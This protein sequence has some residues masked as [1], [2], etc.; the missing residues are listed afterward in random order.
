MSWQGI[1]MARGD[2]RS[3][4]V[5]VKLSDIQT[6]FVAAGITPPNGMFQA[7]FEARLMLRL[8]S[9]PYGEEAVFEVPFERIDTK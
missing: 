8:R 2:H 9:E 7:K 4:G 1:A 3:V 5:G 6:A